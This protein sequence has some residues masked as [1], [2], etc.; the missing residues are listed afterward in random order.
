MGGKIQLYSAGWVGG[1]GGSMIDDSHNNILR[2]VTQMESFL[3]K[4][5][6]EVLTATKTTKRSI[7]CKY[8]D[9]WLT[10]FTSS[11]FLTAALSSLVASR[12]TRMVGRQ[13]IMLFGG[14]M[15]LAGAILN[16]A[17]I[18]IAMLIIGRMLLGFGVG[19]T[20]QVPYNMT[21]SLGF[22]LL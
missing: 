2:G 9:Q 18:N 14:A 6:P 21:K 19:F 13:R 4:F 1:S 3:S 10:T 20:F 11:L 8:D 17:A 5:F 7:Y 22:A 16:G 12:F 15:F